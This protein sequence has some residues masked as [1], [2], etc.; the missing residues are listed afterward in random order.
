MDEMNLP[1]QHQPP[2][3]AKQILDA[4]ITLGDCITQDVLENPEQRLRRWPIHNHAIPGEGFSETVY[5]HAVRQG[6]MSRHTDEAS[7]NAHRPFWAFARP[8]FEFERDEAYE[9]IVDSMTPVG[10][11]N[12]TI[13]HSATFHINYN[14]LSSPEHFW[15][16]ERLW[17]DKNVPAWMGTLGRAA[18]SLRYRRQGLLDEERVGA[19]IRS[20][21]LEDQVSAAPMNMI[22]SNAHVFAYK[23]RYFA[24]QQQEQL[25]Y[26]PHHFWGIGLYDEKGDA[27]GYVPFRQRQAQPDMFLNP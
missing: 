25:Q 18:L 5:N 27:V 4:L 19:E 12:R 17:E 23:K 26:D 13:T 1:V 8:Y 9:R 10:A 6:F 2:K 11:P 7:F 20:M 14:F 3:T 24:L 16:P 21:L 22:P 15:L